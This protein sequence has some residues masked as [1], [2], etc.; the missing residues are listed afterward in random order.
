M[1]RAIFRVKPHV[2]RDAEDFCDVTV[3]HG[4]VGHQHYRFTYVVIND[5]IYCLAYSAAELRTHLTEWEGSPL[6]STCKGALDF[7]LV[8]DSSLSKRRDR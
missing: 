6:A 4:A 2:S 5:F 3:D 1:D 7:V 8:S